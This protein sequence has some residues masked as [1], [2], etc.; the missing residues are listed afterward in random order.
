MGRVDEDRVERAECNQKDCA[1]IVNA[2]Q[3]DRK[4]KPRSDR[5]WPERLQRRINV[6]PDSG[7]PADENAERRTDRR[8]EH[9]TLKHPLAREYYGL[10]PGSAIGVEATRVLPKGPHGPAFEH[11]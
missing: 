3:R 9:K 7:A 5:N 2:E 10:D 1:G 8:R 11:L 6:T 4:G